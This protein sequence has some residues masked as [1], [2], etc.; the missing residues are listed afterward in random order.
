MTTEK[1][2]HDLV[3]SDRAVFATTSYAISSLVQYMETKKITF[4]KE[5]QRSEVWK[6]KKK[7]LLIDSI[8]RL[9]NINYVFFRQTENGVLECLDGQQRLRAIH[10]FYNDKFKITKD[11]TEELDRDYKYS[12][13]PEFI[14]DR[15]KGFIVHAVMVYN[16]DDEETSRIF[17]RLQEGVPLN[18][19]EKLNAIQSIARKEVYEL[20]G[21]EFI[22]KTKISEYRFNKRYVLSQL[23][24]LMIKSQ[25]KDDKIE[26]TGVTGKELIN[27][28]EQSKNRLPDEQALNELKSTLNFLNDEFPD[29]TIIKNNSDLVTLALVAWHLKKYYYNSQG[30]HLRDF[31]ID[32]KQREKAVSAKPMENDHLH[33]LNMALALYIDYT[34]RS[35][36]SKKAIGE[37]FKV[38]LSS[39]LLNNPTIIKKDNRRVFDYYEKLAIWQK[40][41]G[42]CERC[43]RKTNF[44]EGEADHK[45]PYSRGGK[46]SIDNGQWLCRNCNRTKSDSIG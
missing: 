42:R 23:L 18:P 40:A 31:F 36:D 19:A 3:N 45:I 29:P 43:G 14:K 24:Y 22:K 39:Y 15:F 7:V 35:T 10:D 2:F 27:F 17:L 46:T 37:R 33:H 30:F 8:L 13:L 6:T 16:S 28:F 41:D 34:K 11:I 38:M 26:F 44:E 20:S 25:I 32:F 4:N 5:Y 21:H 12:E 9:Y 1:L